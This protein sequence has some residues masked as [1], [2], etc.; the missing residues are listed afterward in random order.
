MSH[1]DFI[2]LSQWIGHPLTQQPAA[3]WR[4]AAID[5]AKQRA[6]AF[7]RAN[8]LTDLKTPPSRRIDL[9]KIALAKRLDSI[10]MLKRRLLRFVQVIENGSGSTNRDFAKFGQPKTVKRCDAELLKQQL[11][12][13]LRSKTPIGTAS[14]HR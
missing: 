12:G 9:D 3:H 8:C 10:K 6:F 14:D 7:A 2:D 11:L 1:V 4:L 5:H 13:S